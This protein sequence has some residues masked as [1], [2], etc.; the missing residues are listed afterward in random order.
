GWH[1]APQEGRTNR[2]PWGAIR[3]TLSV[4]YTV[5]RYPKRCIQADGPRASPPQMDKETYPIH[6]I[7]AFQ[8]Y[9]LHGTCGGL[10]R[11][12]ATFSQSHD[13]DNPLIR[14]LN[15][16]RENTKNLNPM[17]NISYLISIFASKSK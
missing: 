9:Y 2:T 10:P 5:R 1:I 3:Y 16:N 7:L 13:D 12:S 17:A 8:T 11:I 6:N 14:N 4:V 15:K